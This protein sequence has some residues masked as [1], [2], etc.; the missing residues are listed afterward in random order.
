MTIVGRDAAQISLRLPAGLRERL[1]TAAQ[2][3]ARSLNSEIVV[4]LEN[5]LAQR[6]AETKTAGQQA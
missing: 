5:A 6:E 4:I 1:K 2:A 3:N